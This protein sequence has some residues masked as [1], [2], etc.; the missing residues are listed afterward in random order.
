VLKTHDRYGNR[1]DLIEFHPAYHELMRTAIEF[2]IP[3]AP[4]TDPRP[5]AP[6]PRAPRDGEE[7]HD[8]IVESR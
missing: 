1:I 5:G 4:W 8:A 6:A 2:G 3:S 7:A